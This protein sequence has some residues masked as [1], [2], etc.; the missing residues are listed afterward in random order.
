MTCF[1]R[2]SRS[3]RATALLLA[4]ALAVLTVDTTG[5]LA[6]HQSRAVRQQFVALAAAPASPPAAQVR[7]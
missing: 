6:R 7:S 4:A 5:A 2:L 1:S 3:L